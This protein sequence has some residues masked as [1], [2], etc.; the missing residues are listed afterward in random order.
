MR[1]GARICTGYLCEAFALMHLGLQDVDDNINDAFVIVVKAILRGDLREP[2]RLLG[3][4][5]TVVRRQLAAHTE[6]KVH[7]LK[8]H[9]H[10]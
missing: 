7:G 5:K 8:D 10:L 3:F 1:A 2:D 4:V 6:Q 9:A